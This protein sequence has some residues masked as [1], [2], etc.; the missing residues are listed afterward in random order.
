MFN[1]N[2]QAV[3]RAP[4]WFRRKTCPG[5]RVS[6]M[7]DTLNVQSTF[8]DLIDAID[9]DFI[10]LLRPLWEAQAKENRFHSDRG[11]LLRMNSKMAAEKHAFLLYGQ[12]VV[13][14][15]NL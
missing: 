8:S 15:W 2:L 1:L 3:L 13:F 11:L 14:L 5:S 6:L 9:R 10:D 7:A 12:C 4:Q